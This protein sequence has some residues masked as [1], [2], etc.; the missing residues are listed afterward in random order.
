MSRKIYKYLSLDS[1]MKTQRSDRKKLYD[2]LEG[3]ENPITIEVM[4]DEGDQ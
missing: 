1:V 3:I 2:S 4:E